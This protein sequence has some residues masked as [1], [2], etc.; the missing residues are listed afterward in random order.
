MADQAATVAVGTVSDALAGA[1]SI[2]R[3]D[4]VCFE[5]RVRAAFER[6]LGADA[7]GDA[8]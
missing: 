2:A 3:V 5:S 4:F 1:P 6:A 7:G 8:A